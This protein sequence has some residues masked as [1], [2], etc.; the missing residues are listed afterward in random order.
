MVF[1][2][3]HIYIT[4]FKIAYINFHCEVLGNCEVHKSHCRKYDGV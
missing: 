1:N 4:P 3:V 2:A